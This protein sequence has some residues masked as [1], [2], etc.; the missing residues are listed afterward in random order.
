MQ[1]NKWIYMTLV[2]VFV[3]EV[4]LSW[5]YRILRYRAVKQTDTYKLRCKL[6][7]R[8]YRRCR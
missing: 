5:L 1:Q 3:C 4:W 7:L 8:D 6:D 2:G